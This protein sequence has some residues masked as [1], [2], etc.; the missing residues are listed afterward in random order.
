MPTFDDSE[1]RKVISE[2]LAGYEGEPILFNMSGEE[3]VNLF[4]DVDENGEYIFALSSRFIDLI[5][6]SNV[7][8]RGFYVNIEGPDK[9]IKKVYRKRSNKEE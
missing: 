5:D 3:L 6:F 4:F 9:Q 7:P 8:V 2:V 1:A